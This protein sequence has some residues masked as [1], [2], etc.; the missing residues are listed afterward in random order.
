MTLLNLIA[1]D[2]GGTTGMA[3]AMFP[4]NG[5]VP[6]AYL[7][8]MSRAWQID[9]EHKDQALL[10][11]QEILD[12]MKRAGGV[13]QSTYNVRTIV[14]CEDFVVPSGPR[15]KTVLSPVRVGAML[16][17]HVWLEELNLEWRW[18]QPG[19]RS[20]ITDEMLKRW[21]LWLPGQ[22]HAMD[23]LR[24]LIVLQRKLEKEKIK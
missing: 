16:E 20:V 6:D 2:P 4:P 24:H 12:C 19:E 10:L 23:A 18:Q 22:P 21:G 13:N 11:Y 7:K 1:L 14:A 15:R 9:G 5:N 8:K 3:W 17:Y